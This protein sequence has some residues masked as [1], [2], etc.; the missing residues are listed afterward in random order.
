[1]KIPTASAVIA[2]ILAS[3][4]IAAIPAGAEDQKPKTREQAV[5]GRAVSTNRPSPQEIVYMA[6]TVKF[7]NTAVT[8][9]PVPPEIRRLNTGFSIKVFYRARSD[10]LEYLP[11]QGA[12]LAKVRIGG[13]PAE[14]N[15]PDGDYYLWIGRG[16]DSLRALLIKIDGTVSKEVEV[17]PKPTTSLAEQSVE[18]LHKVRSLSLPLPGTTPLPPGSQHPPPPPPPR[19]TWREIWVPVPNTDHQGGGR[20]IRVPDN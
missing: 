17:V 16:V 9:Q 19:P 6:R 1:M 5:L 12:V 15:L 10:T 4:V 13:V 14:R 7:D 2:C 18:P 11:E 8:D 20:W 3:S